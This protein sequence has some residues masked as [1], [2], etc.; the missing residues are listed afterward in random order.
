ML[1]APKAQ[2]HCPPASA[3]DAIAQSAHVME[4]HSKAGPHLVSSQAALAS[5]VWPKVSPSPQPN[6]GSY[7]SSSPPSSPPASPPPLS[8]A[9]RS[10]KCWPRSRCAGRVGQT[11]SGRPISGKRRGGN[12]QLTLAAAASA[13]IASTVRSEESIPRS[14][15]IFFFASGQT[16]KR[17][18]GDSGSLAQLPRA[19]ADGGRV[20]GGVRVSV[21]LRPHR[22][23]SC[24]H[25]GRGCQLQRH[26]LRL[27]EHGGSRAPGFTSS[28]RQRQFLRVSICRQRYALVHHRDDRL[29][30]IQDLPRRAGPLGLGWWVHGLRHR[31]LPLTWVE[32][33]GSVLYQGS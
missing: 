15:T 33:S 4:K 22:R 25:I 2:S 27:A 7:A 16:T 5:S 9:R 28:D 26:A 14:Q 12:P 21:V 11:L 1:C 30:W 31:W 19:A 23:Y 24:V 20:R 8:E 6:C 17:Q 3:A 10:E 13:R 32:C 29:R 18:R